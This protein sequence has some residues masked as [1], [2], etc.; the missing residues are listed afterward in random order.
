MALV[1]SVSCL[2]LQFTR[3]TL[4]VYR[5]VTVFQETKQLYTVK[6]KTD[7]IA[8]NVVSIPKAAEHRDTVYDERALQWTTEITRITVYPFRESFDY[9]VLGVFKV[10]KDTCDV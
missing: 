1:R 9:I 4:N 2:R 3:L 8:T 7:S 10:L 6:R 5:F